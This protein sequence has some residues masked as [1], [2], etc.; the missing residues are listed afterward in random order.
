MKFIDEVI[1]T[2]KAG[3]GGRGCSSFRHEARNYKGGPDG[4]NGGKG[5]NVVFA[6]D[7]G[8][9]TLLDFKYQARFQAQR[10]EHGRGSDCHGAGAHDLRLKVPLGTMVYDE[11]TGELIAD[12]TAAGQQWIAAK[13]GRGGRGN[14]AFKSSTNR[15]PRRADPGEPGEEFKLRLELKLIADVGLVGRPNAGKSTLIS[16]IS[17]AHPKIADY[18]FTTLTPQLGVVRA[19]ESGGFVVADMPG[20]IEG[21][22]Q[23]HGL[24]LQFLKP[25]R[26]DPAS[27]PFGRV[28]AAGP[29]GRSADD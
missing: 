12:L 1:I 19:G 8:L 17:A 27:A 4:G 7:P 21:A 23:G 10:G 25:H 24:G 28:L 22:S 11:K 29:G 6:A 18:P 13:G 9:G 2:V 15:A 5:G 14:L 20:L 26:A 16:R 3:D